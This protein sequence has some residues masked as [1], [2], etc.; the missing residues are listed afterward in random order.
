MDT[1]NNQPCNPLNVAILRILQDHTDPISEYELLQL[2]DPQL[3]EPLIQDCCADVVLFRKH[4]LV[5]N[6]LY[7]LNDELT[8]SG[9]QLT[10][11]ALHIQIHPISFSNG[12]CR[13]LSKQ[14]AGYQRLAAYYKNW[15]NFFSTQ[16]ADVQR[17]FKQFWERFF[18]HKDNKQQALEILGLDDSE[19][20]NWAA[21]KQQYRR[22]CQQH[23]P[24]KGGSQL[25]FVEI[26]QAYSSLK[27]IFC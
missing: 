18:D 10:I 3:F 5:M 25:F 12:T 20:L 22:L 13:H 4:F 11:S 7:H 15:D 24:D 19:T 17:L 6:A 9:Y 21:I 14:D 2:L 8:K 23:H 16:A 27:Q 1:L 26:Q